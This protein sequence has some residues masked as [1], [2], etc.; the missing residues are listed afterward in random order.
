M[1]SDSQS[2]SLP[3]STAT[4]ED[5]FFSYFVD[6]CLRD[7]ELRELL[8]F[9]D[10]VV[11]PE[12]ELRTHEAAHELHRLAT[13]ELLLCLPLELRIKRLRGQHEVGPAEDVLGED[14]H[15]LRLQAVRLHEGEHGLI[16]AVLEPRLMRAA[17]R[18]RDEVH[19]A[20]ALKP[21]LGRPDDD[22]GRALAHCIAVTG[23]LNVTMRLEGSD[24]RF[25][26]NLGEEVFAKAALILPAF[27]PT[28]LLIL[29]DHFTAGKQHGLRAKQ[30]NERTLGN[31]GAVEVLR[32]RMSSH[33][34]ARLGLRTRRTGGLEGA[35]DIAVGKADR[36]L[37]AVAPDGD[38]ERSRKCVRH[39][40]ADA[41]QTARKE[42]RT[43]AVGLG[44]L[45]ACVQP[46]EDKLDNRHLLLR[47]KPRRDASA[48]VLDRD[49]PVGMKRHRYA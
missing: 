42:I 34:R 47:M 10:V 28:S 41:V 36:R 49:A 6:W 1:S 7:D 21:S 15:V 13:R 27:L 30:A 33:T 31:R 18:R 2:V 4:L 14:L 37:L 32:I 16:Q 12:L 43:R 20:L 48:V 22:P 45:A 8:A 35:D 26:C 29:V 5:F 17:L 23:I 9:L 44:E 11:E 19:I 25:S 40:D 46:R 38:V 3:G 24:K 39:R